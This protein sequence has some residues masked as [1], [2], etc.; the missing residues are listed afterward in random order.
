MARLCIWAAEL[1]GVVGAAALTTPVIGRRDVH[2]PPAPC[3]RELD[4]FEK[5]AL[6]EHQDEERK[7]EALP[8][9]APQGR[10]AAGIIRVS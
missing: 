6:L 9:N 1:G 2:A 3:C 10:R 5:V 4:E 7:L 8:A